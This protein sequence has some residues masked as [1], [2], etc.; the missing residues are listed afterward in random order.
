MVRQFSFGKVCGVCVLRLN[1][2][3]APPVE[4]RSWWM[5]QWWGSMNG[6]ADANRLTQAWR[7]CS[8]WTDTEL[9]K[10]YCE[11]VHLRPCVLF[12]FTSTLLVL[13]MLTCWFIN[14]T[15]GA[16]RQWETAATD[17]IVFNENSRVAEV[18]GSNK[19]R[20]AGCCSFE[21]TQF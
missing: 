17:S 6:A 4:L 13:N 10:F 12:S 14:I 15:Q 8:A 20:Q 11:T 5:S 16:L 9:C 3:L 7:R 18:G 2:P 19:E 21:S 1:N